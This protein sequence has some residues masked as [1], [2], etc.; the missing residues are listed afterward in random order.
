[1]AISRFARLFVI[2]NEVIAQHPRSTT[3]ERSAEIPE[4]NDIGS[5]S[6]GDDS[7]E[8]SDRAAS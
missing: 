6:E 2:L 1:V 4:A 5:L 7:S 3:Q 8:L